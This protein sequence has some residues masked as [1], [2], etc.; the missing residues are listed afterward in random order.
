[1]SLWSKVRN[2]LDMAQVCITAFELIGELVKKRR[3]IDTLD[4]VATIVERVKA[5][6]AGKEDPAKAR[7]DFDKMKADLAQNNADV[8]AEVDDRFDGSD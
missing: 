1:M 4:V 5:V 7:A 3:S 2:G 8:D 6:F